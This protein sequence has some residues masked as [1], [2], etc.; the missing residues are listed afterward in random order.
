[1]AKRF[2]VDQYVD[3]IL[4]GDR[5]VLS[6]AI[7]LV[8]STLPAD[9]ELA[10]QVLARLLPATG[11]SLRIG[12]TGP[13]GVGK[14]TFIE[15]FGAWLVAR[16]AC[17]LAVLAVD[18]SSQQSGGSIL[19]DKTRMAA[20]AGLPQVYIRP[21]PAGASLGG[22]ARH[23]REAIFLCEAAGFDLILVET[24]GVGQSE[25]QVHSMVD[26]F[27]LLLQAGAGDELQGIKK[28]I[29]EMA[30]G[31]AITKADGANQDRARQA[32]AEYRR[33]LHLFPLPASGFAPQVKLCSGLEATGLEE[34][35]EMITAYLATSRKQ[36]YFNKKRQE[37]NLHWMHQ[38]I[39]QAL[40]DRFYHAPA[41]QAQLPELESQVANGSK[42]PFQAASEL[43]HLAAASPG[44]NL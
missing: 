27:L 41:V 5:V 19:G 12:I 33:A 8:E 31:L 20:L 9:Q 43:L 21:S 2:Y 34:I 6:R 26:F 17:R 40:Y 15:A 22:V 42:S 11:K 37:Q 35:W 4:A 3:R 25:T 1:M 28:G 13:P 36:G 7:T 23:T 29:M 14:S 24:V 16:Q 39:H 10:Q 18:P 32:Q 38:T 44:L 30:D